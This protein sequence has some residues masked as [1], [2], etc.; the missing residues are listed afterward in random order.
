M[1]KKWLHFAAALLLALP[2]AGM[3]A[4]AGLEQARKMLASGRIDEGTKL[5]EEALARI[6][7]YVKKNPGDA[8][9]IVLYG[10]VCMDLGAARD[11]FD[12]Y[13][14]AC[15][16]QPENTDFILKKVALLHAVG[17]LEGCEAEIDKAARLAPANLDFSLMLA[18][19][20][21]SR[22]DGDGALKVVQAVLQKAPGRAD[23]VT[24]AGNVH[25]AMGRR[26]KAVE[27]YTRAVTLDPK[28]SQAHYNMGL[29][30]QM[31]GKPAKAEAPFLKAAALRPEDDQALSK[32]VQVYEATGETSKRDAQLHAIY[33]LYESGKAP[34]LSRRGFFGRDQFETAGTKVMVFEH[35]ALQGPFGVKY[36]F[37]VMN[38]D[39]V[40]PRYRLSLGSYDYTNAAC[41]ELG[42]VESGKRLYHLDG[43]YPDGMHATY[44][45]FQGEP[46]Y[47]ETKAT[48]CRIVSGE[49]QALSSSGPHEY[50]EE[51]EN[52]QNPGEKEK[53]GRES[54]IGDP[55]PPSGT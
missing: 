39:G 28:S 36:V 26:D 4:D 5:L 54:P 35:F 18:E 12:A 37:Y 16:L 38:R 48:V 7:E 41:K 9:A 24:L 55:P 31:D 17:D 45:F 44:G 23:A 42:T 27:E 53:N 19:I 11:A 30:W 6:G 46:P 34:V 2:A 52:T 49:Q 14:K 1:I 50:L 13:D 22:G 20:K 40:T 29:A 10:D 32:L 33:A 3:D 47:G 8:A 15:R 43:Y 51:K 25:L 21:L